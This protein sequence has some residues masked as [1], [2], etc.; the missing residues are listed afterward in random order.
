AREKARL[1]EEE[2]NKA[3]MEAEME[4]G[5]WQQERELMAEER[6]LAAKET[7]ER[8]KNQISKLKAEYDDIVKSMRKLAK[9]AE[10][11]TTSDVRETLMGMRHE[12]QDKIR[13]MDAVVAGIMKSAEY[14]DELPGR[15]ATPADMKL[16]SAVFVLPVKKEGTIIGINSP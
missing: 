15:P 7:A 12:A 6:H 5:R 3:R 14:G 1:R 10:R 2:L 8:Y 4:K 13:E 9:D 16:G 11:A